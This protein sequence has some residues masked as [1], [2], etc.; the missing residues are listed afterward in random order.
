MLGNTGSW[1]QL[2]LILHCIFQTFQTQAN[3]SLRIIHFWVYA[4]FEYPNKTAESQAKQ[5]GD[6]VPSVDTQMFTERPT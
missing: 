4:N 1:L 6:Y 3:Q 5:N 2:I